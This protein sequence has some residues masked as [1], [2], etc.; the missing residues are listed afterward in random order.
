[1]ELKPSK[2][3]KEIEDFSETLYSYDQFLS[4][5]AKKCTSPVGCGEPVKGFRD[6]LSRKEYKISGLCQNCQDKIFGEK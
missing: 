2:K 4:V 6:A 3:S 5:A 1:M